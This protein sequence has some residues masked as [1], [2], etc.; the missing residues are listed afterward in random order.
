MKNLIL[1]QQYGVAKVDWKLFSTRY[2]SNVI[3]ITLHE[4]LANLGEAKNSFKNI[5][6]SKDFSFEYIKVMVGQIIRNLLQEGIEKR[7]IGVI[8]SDE[9]WLVNC[10]KLTE[11]FDLPGA[12][13]NQV[14]PFKNKLE[15]KKALHDMPNIYPKH[16]RFDPIEY[17]IN[18]SR[19][20]REIVEQ[21]G[22]P[23]FAKPIDAS[24]SIGA[25]KISSQTELEK[26]C[27]N[28]LD[29]ENYE[30]DEF[31]DGEIFHCDSIVISGK[32]LFTIVSKYHNL[33]AQ[34]ADDF[35]L[36]SVAIQEDDPIYLRMVAFNDMILAKM[37]PPNG[38]THLE[39]FLTADDR[40][41]FIEVA[42]RMPGAMVPEAYE[43]SYDFNFREFHYAAQ[44]GRQVTIPK[45]NGMYAGWAYLPPRPGK[46]VKFLPLDHFQSDNKLVEF[47]K[48]GDVVTKPASLIDVVAGVLLWNHDREQLLADLKSLDCTRPILIEPI[49]NTN[50]R[51]SVTADSYQNKV[52][53]NTA[54]I[55]QPIYNHLSLSLDQQP[56]IGLLNKRLDNIIKAN[57]RLLGKHFRTECGELVYTLDSAPSCIENITPTQL[58]EYL[59]SHYCHNEEKLFRVFIVNHQKHR[60][61]S[62]VTH[63][64]ILSSELLYQLGRLFVETDNTISFILENEYK[65]IA[66]DSHGDLL[67]LPLKKENVSY[68][69]TRKFQVLLH[70][71]VSVSTKQD[72]IAYLLLFLNRYS[73]KDI[74][75]ISLRTFDAQNATRQS[76]GIDFSSINTVADIVVAISHKQKFT[77]SERVF[78]DDRQPAV[79]ILSPDYEGVSLDESHGTHPILIEYCLGENKLNVQLNED[80]FTSD[81]AAQ[82]LES[83]EYYFSQTLNLATSLADIEILS[84]SQKQRILELSNHQRDIQPNTIFNMIFSAE[85]KLTNQLAV[86]SSQESI[87]YSELANRVASF[88]EIL[89]QQRLTQNAVIAVY[90]DR[91]IEMVIAMLAAWRLGYT[92]LPIAKN[93]PVE[94]FDHVVSDAKVQLIITNLPLPKYYPLKVIDCNNLSYIP[95]DTL[96]QQPSDAAP[97][98]VAYI[99]YTSGTTGLPKGVQVSHSSICHQ[100]NWMIANFGV[101][102]DDKILHKTPISFDVSLWELLLP[103]ASGGQLVLL[104]SG[105]ELNP[106]FMV[107]EIT[108]KRISMLHFVPPVLELVLSYIRDNLISQD[109]L[110]SLRHV[111]CSGSSLSE[112]LREQFHQY[113]PDSCKLSNLYGPTEGVIDHTFHTFSQNESGEV[114]IGQPIPGKSAYILNSKQ[115]LLPQG[116][117]G[118]IVLGGVLAIGYVGETVNN[119]HFIS[120]Q[121][122][123]TGDLGIIMND[124]IYY[125]GRCD[126]QIKLNG[127]RIELDGIE[128]IVKRFNSQL[129]CAVI[130]KRNLQGEVTSLVIFLQGEVDLFKL[131]QFVQNNISFS[132]S[133]LNYQQVS[134]LPL[135]SNQKIS[136]KALETQ[137]DVLGPQ[138]LDFKMPQC[139]TQYSLIKIWQQV[140]QKESQISIADNFFELGGNSVFAVK[141]LALIK[142][143][144][145]K[146]IAVSDFLRSP[147]IATIS[148]LLGGNFG[149]SPTDPILPL[150]VRKNLPASFWIHPVGGLGFPYALL[151]DYLEGYSTYAISDPYFS[152]DQ[153]SFAS[154]TEMAEYYAK[155]IKKV[156]PEGTYVIG[157]V[158]FGGM[159]ALEV[160]RI[161]ENTGNI[162]QAVVLIDSYNMSKADKDILAK[163]EQ[164]QIPRIIDFLKQD[165]VDPNSVE[166]LAMIKEVRTNVLL[167]KEHIPQP[168][169]KRVILIKA[170]IA[171]AG[172][173]FGFASDPVNGWTPEICP[174]LIVRSVTAMHKN[175]ISIE[176]IAAVCALINAELSRMP[177]TPL[178]DHVNSPQ[179]HL[180]Y[181]IV[182]EDV[183]LIEQILNL[184]NEEPFLSQELVAMLQAFALKYPQLNKLKMWPKLMMRSNEMKVLILVQQYGS[185]KIDWSKVKKEHDCKLYAIVNQESE[186][187]LIDKGYNAAFEKIYVESQFTVEKIALHIQ[188]VVSLYQSIQIQIA[189]TDE[190]AILL[191]GKI[192]ELFNLPGPTYQ[193]LLPFR[194]KITM[195]K[196][197]AG[198]VDT[199]LP[200]YVAFD[201]EAYNSNAEAYIDQVILKVGLPAFVKPIDADA[202]REARKISSKAELLERCN[203]MIANKLEFEI[204]QF[205]SGELYHC[206]SLIKDGKIILSMVSKYLYPVAEFLLG[207]PCSSI[208]LEKDDPQYQQSLQ[209]NELILNA[210]PNVHN[211]CTHL[212]FMVTPENQFYFI[213]IAARSPGALVPECIEISTGINL[214]EVHC[215]LQ[216]GFDVTPIPKETGCY[217]SWAYFPQK[218]GKVMEIIYPKHFDSDYQIATAID[219]NIEISQSPRS[220]LDFVY[221]MTFSNTDKY[222]LKQDFESLRNFT[223]LHVFRK[224]FA[225]NRTLSLDSPIISS[226]ALE[227]SEDKLVTNSNTITG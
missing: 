26:W 159:V 34:F 77:E 132:S 106:E 92:Y 182:N 5:Y 32:I 227:V 226:Q 114:P 31:I 216:G 174:H 44:A 89:V 73:N 97:N 14:I 197:L 207:K 150:K 48:P 91:S 88:A 225:E 7:H 146:S 213:E 222:K 138:T 10:A 95:P 135:S 201:L 204:D 168:F 183:F 13:L 65:Q 192:R 154:I 127:V 66:A 155:A 171:D 144:F 169:P 20:L 4:T 87:T 176:N 143:R 165:G 28:H 203:F 25:Q 101:S 109:L 217:A 85:D 41:I 27:D 156:Q 215:L 153:F 45:F 29:A 188:E 105:E 141:M 131:K 160:A 139:Y 199:H 98:D 164:L 23:I 104:D 185:Y 122:Y 194:N 30:L 86:V 75:S 22:L 15:M 11:E 57:P 221:T 18:K 118:E 184:M 180:K 167:Q 111:V 64:L 129:N 125:R 36:A 12:G 115:Q 112:H 175:I 152:S 158:S 84:E 82:F 53:I 83:L 79:S 42:A 19:Y 93:Y 113:L 137:L 195:K 117:V 205:I 161:L 128:A 40:I 107:N 151:S 80:F 56:D 200:K 16:C 119:S 206:D 130:A 214:R 190:Q 223:P 96:Q 100:I 39:C 67:F 37:N 189:S 202:S 72:I 181:A 163:Y 140:L 116:V 148:T 110:A 3:L 126:R 60:T 166:G 47:R 17:K 59:N 147:T 198:K 149:D 74:T 142:E 43:K 108:T 121:L 2:D 24:A 173:N 145:G 78:W 6:T 21:L 103:L 208:L 162:V 69:Y 170:Q 157:G 1:V 76:V 186:K 193:D 38:G 70:N 133:S 46:I 177:S 8:T 68:R 58:Q 62:I 52:W 179:A 196:S 61:L 191:C 224:D 102:P 218:I 54:L 94:L 124:K 33:P 71:N 211:G 50:L 178:S 35:I 220:L 210:L 51:D 55:A 90:M 120:N 219:T 134:T 9:D 172:R 81:L 136:Y 63:P 212:E 99:I 187:L 49:E 209:F 123:R